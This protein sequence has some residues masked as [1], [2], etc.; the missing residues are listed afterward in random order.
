MVDY[1]LFHRQR[2][3]QF[4]IAIE[5][6]YSDNVRLRRADLRRADEFD[7]DKMRSELPGET[8]RD[9]PTNIANATT[10]SSGGD[11]RSGNGKLGD[12][13]DS[14]S[15]DHTII[16][17][18]LHRRLAWLSTGTSITAILVTLDRMRG[19]PTF[20]ERAPEPFRKT[21]AQQ[22]QPQSV[23]AAATSSFSIPI[24]ATV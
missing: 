4:I 24:T 23:N 16:R 18:I 1:R 10:R 9:D 21:L 11:R 8:R 20:P 2:V 7:V 3:Y 14:P 22:G 13:D 12:N 17:P 5:T 15:S 19:V 6:T